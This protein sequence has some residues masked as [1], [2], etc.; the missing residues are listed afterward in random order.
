[1]PEPPS[2][3]LRHGS[4]VKPGMTPRFLVNQHATGKRGRP[5]RNPGRP[6]RKTTARCA[7][8]PPRASGGAV[9][10]AAGRIAVDGVGQDLGK[11]R[12][13]VLARKPGLLGDGVE[14]LR[15][16]RLLEI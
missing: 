7:R 16:E 13:Q 5:G 3:T 11:P 6:A 2:E 15:P 8:S 4:R 1:M 10:A 12:Q 9:Q 14:H